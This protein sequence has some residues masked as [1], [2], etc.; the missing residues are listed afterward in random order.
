MGNNPV[1]SDKYFC[2][3][4]FANV[5]F[6]SCQHTVTDLPVETSSMMSSITKK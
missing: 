6:S 4:V 5:I 2:Y 3:D 1:K